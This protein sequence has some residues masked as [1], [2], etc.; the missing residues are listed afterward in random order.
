MPVNVSLLV[1]FLALS[2]VLSAIPGPSVLLA[3]SRA[4]TRGRRQ[5]MW[6]VLG[7]GAGGI[8]LL[9]LVLAG[10]GAIVSASAK[11]F[12]VVKFA[13]AL[14][15]LWLGIQAIRS[16][17]TLSETPDFPEDPGIADSPLLA[18][19]QGFLVGAV[20]PKSI[21][22]LMAMLPQ[23]VDHRIGA[24]VLQMAIIGLAGG[25]VQVSIESLWVGA[26]GTLRSWFQRR[27]QRLQGLRVGGGIIMIGLSGRLALDR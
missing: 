10:L 19:R 4:I 7:S 1:G 8:F 22:S 21:V 16:A 5:A 11:L 6:I 23:F 14:Y 3:S 17:R 26:A 9:A 12:M 2:A 25:L 24:P 18:L 27:P 13:G 20:N 15:L